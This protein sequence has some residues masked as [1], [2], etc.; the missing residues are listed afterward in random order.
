MGDPL[1]REPPEGR[2]DEHGVGYPPGLLEL[3]AHA[4]RGAEGDEGARH[5]LADA[6]GSTLRVASLPA[7]ARVGG[8]AAEAALLEEARVL[9]DRRVGRGEAPRVGERRAL[10]GI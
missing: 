9:R 2:R 10:V 6:L 5:L 8:L 1:R 7:L 3:G 4:L